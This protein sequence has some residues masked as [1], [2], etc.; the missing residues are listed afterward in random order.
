MLR[1]SSALDSSSPMVREEPHVLLRRGWVWASVAKAL[2]LFLLP[3]PLLLAVTLAGACATL[4]HSMRATHGALLATR[5]VDLAAD[6]TEVLRDATSVQE[7]GLMFEA[8]REQVQVALPVAGLAPEEIAALA[9]MPGE[10][11]PA[12]EAGSRRFELIMH[13]HGPPGTGLREMRLPVSAWDWSNEPSSAGP[14]D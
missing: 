1:S 14:Y 10:V 8:W 9:P 2:A 11:E 13:W 5:A 7:A 4:I 6:L 3:L 12:S